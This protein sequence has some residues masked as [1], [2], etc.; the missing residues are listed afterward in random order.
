M[1]TLT[2]AIS[3]LVQLASGPTDIFAPV[4]TPA[5]SIF[6][7]S[8]FVL[9]ITGA[10]FVVV[11]ALLAYSAIRFRKR[12]SDDGRE[13]AQVYGS[14]QVELA[15]TLTPVLISL[16]L[17]LATARVIF[18]IQHPAP[19]PGAVE[20][21]VIGHQFWWEYRYPGLKVV[22]ANE[23]HVPVSDP[24]HPTPTF[25]KLYSAD[26]DH[27]W[28]VPRLAGKTDLIPNHPNS[29]WIEPR[30][31][32]LYLGQCAQ[33]CGTQHAKMLLRVYVESP[34]D[35]AS[36]I[37][38]QRQ[39]VQTAPS[40]GTASEGRKIFERVACINCHTVAG[41]PAN[42]R[43]GPDLTHLMSRET[44]ASGAAPNTRENL[45]RW[46]ENPS[47]LKPGCKMPAMGLTNQQLD[48]VTAYLVSL[49]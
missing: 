48:A 7:L 24:A 25:L 11:A 20:V 37:Q 27:S 49:R 34:E 44:I 18:Q 22:T 10:I 42:G 43:F 26:T 19:P 36:W 8:L 1:I 4:S 17:F 9:G 38:E 23:L 33:Y 46:I 14:L 39:T 41:T 21:T 16:V 30:E 32:G 13:P 45:R 40:D 31:T 35:F 6:D 47:A 15:W 29:M 2:T 12:K 5:Q 3:E 28:W